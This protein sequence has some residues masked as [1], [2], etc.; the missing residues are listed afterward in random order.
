[1]QQNIQFAVPADAAWPTAVRL[2]GCSRPF[3]VTGCGSGSAGCDG[4]SLS[5]MAVSDAAVPA[6][7]VPF[8]PS[9]LGYHCREAVVADP[10]GIQEIQISASFQGA[11]GGA[12]A[13]DDFDLT[14]TEPSCWGELAYC[15]GLR[16]IW[17]GE[18]VAVPP[19][20]SPTVSPSSA[21]VTVVFKV[22]MRGWDPSTVQ[23]LFLTSFFDPRPACDWFF[24]ALHAPPCHIFILFNSPHGDQGHRMLIV[25]CTPML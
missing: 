24:T 4:Y 25:A 2:R 7:V 12:A 13:F 15:R 21:F 18:S 17:A 10:A 3:A 16:G 19:T 1:V 6:V 23:R 22:D 5:A 9:A 14:V 20:P 11:G 8:D